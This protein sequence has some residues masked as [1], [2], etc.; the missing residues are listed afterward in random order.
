MV[1]EIKS[2]GIATVE[3]AADVLLLFSQSGQA[4]LGITE[5]AKSLGL[6][7]AAVHRIL[8]SLRSRDF[9]ELIEDTRRYTLGASALA[10]GLT[11][12]AQLDIRTLA[13]PE[14]SILS[15]ATNETATL[16]IR[17]GYQR[18]YIDQVIPNREIV[19]SVAM[20]IT[21][22]LHAGSSSKAFLAWLPEAERHS[23][24]KRKLKQLTPAT[25]TDPVKI[26][27]ELRQIRTRGYS[28][29]VGERQQGS[30]SIAAPIFD[31]TGAPIAVISICGPSDRFKS[32]L[33]QCVPLLLDSA[34]RLSRRM[35]HN[36]KRK[37]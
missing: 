19:M 16:S 30:A 14:L 29:T 37:F 1:T 7:K 24:L 6:S 9:I 5:I 22:P 34:A 32:E 23:F 27:Q 20:G 15:R 33:P 35:G 3:R 8:V 36:P 18:L 4:D 31:R 28:Q 12:L 13:A 17:A 26:T 21:H 2:Q 10:L 11:C 25:P